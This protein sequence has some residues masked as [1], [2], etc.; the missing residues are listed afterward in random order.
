MYGHE[1]VAEVFS[2][3]EIGEE[4]PA[5]CAVFG[6]F[7]VFE[8]GS[9]PERGGFGA[10]VEVCGLVEAGVVMV[11]HEGPTAFFDD[12]VEAFAR[13]WA[14]PDDIAEAND[15][16]NASLFDVFEDGGHRFEVAVN[17]RDGGDRVGDAK[18]SEKV[19]GN[20]KNADDEGQVGV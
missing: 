17:I 11:S 2:D 15:A 6:V 20:V 12:E 4:L 8:L 5:S 9:C 3:C 13:I 14:I 16:F 19:D 7:F 1:V 10:D 18:F